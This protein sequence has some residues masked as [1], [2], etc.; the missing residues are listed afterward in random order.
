MINRCIV[1]LEEFTYLADWEGDPGRTLCRGY[2]KIFR[3]SEDA[4]SALAR[5]RECREFKNARIIPIKITPVE[6]G[7]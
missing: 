4:T 7:E 3:S 2:A 5:A 1:E 6:T